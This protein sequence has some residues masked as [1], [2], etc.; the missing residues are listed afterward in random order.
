MKQ[1]LLLFLTVILLSMTSVFAQSG[2]TGPLTWEITGNTL[3]ISGIGAMPNYIPGT[4]PAP[5]AP[6]S[7]TTIIIENGVTSIGNN[8]FMSSAVVTIS[9]PESITAIGS[10]AFYGCV[11]LG[12]ATIPP[13]VTFIGDSVFMRCAALATLHFNATNCDSVGTSWLLGTNFL[14]VVGTVSIGANVERVPDNF[15]SNHT[16]ITSITIPGAVTKIGNSAFRGCTGLNSIVIPNAVESIENSAFQGCTGLTSVTIGSAVT[17]IGFSVFANCTALATVNYNA[18][19][20][21]SIFYITDTNHWLF[22]TTSLLTVIIGENVQIIPSNFIRGRT[23]ITSIIIPDAV[24]TI[25]NSAFRGCSG[26]NSIIIPNAVTSIE[27]SAFNSCTGLTSATI[28]SAVTSIGQLTFANCTALATINFNAVNCANIS[29]NSHWL[30]GTTS[31]TTIVIG[32]N[33]EGIPDN[34]IRAHTGITSIIIPDAVTT[35]GISAFQ[36]SGIASITFPDALTVIDNSAFQGCTGL[37]SIEIPNLVTSIG[38]LAFAN[39]TALET[40]TFNAVNCANFYFSEDTVTSHWLRNTTSLTTVVIGENVQRIPDNVFRNRNGITTVTIPNSVTL[41][42]NGAFQDCTGLESIVVGNSV[43]SIGGYAFYNCNALLSVTIP[44]SVANIGVYAFGECTGLT[45]IVTDAVTPPNTG[46]SAFNNVPVNIPVHIPCLTYSNYKNATGWVQFTNFITNGPVSP[47]TVEY[48]RAKCPGAPF[49]DDNF[50]TPIY[51]PGTYCAILVNV[52]NCDSVVCLILS[53]Y[54]NLPVISYTATFCS[55]SSYSDAN[56][57]NLTQP[58]T[59]EVVYPNLHGCDSIVRLQL[60]YPAPP[61]SQQLCMVSTN[62]NNHNEIVWKKQEE[63]VSYNIYRDDFLTGNYVLMANIESSSPNF[64]I[65]M[66][67]Y[68]GHSYV[69]TGVD[70]CGTQSTPG[71]AHRVMFLEVEKKTDN[72]W[73]LTWNAY[74]GTS[75]S[76]YKIYR[77][78]GATLGEMEPI[79]S[80]VAGGDIISFN[81]PAVPKDTVYYMIEIELSEPCFLGKNLSSIRSNIVMID[82]NT[83]TINEI[84]VDN[85]KLFPNPVKNELFITSD[86]KIDKVELYT[87][88]GSLVISE[89]N[90]TGKISTRSLVPG[91]YFVRVYTEKGIFEKKVVK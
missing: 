68:G 62:E 83:N 48:H 31:L 12:S 88:T 57:T 63:V 75:F 3:T 32:E 87:L 59:Y 34:F 36:G 35:I 61:P 22:G 14:G 27:N 23:G 76:T 71:T 84:A 58:G 8:A 77:S 91:L 9:I 64:W 65:D 40:V 42:G 10:A 80:I 2:T 60:T 18:T 33:V 73:T 28:G 78:V 51:D 26:L 70:S 43:I 41:I 5:W 55:G 52:D 49:T 19:N 79:H 85:I 39:C 29:E 20:C 24:T 21:I 15:I 53:E 50:T 56:F 44:N 72:S 66:T 38:R 25:G 11:G 6:Y 30:Q 67:N 37:T 46:I 90:F 4:L 7:V 47:G 54:Q 89:Q 69:I 1:K 74:K 82:N 86:S 81:D 16:G 45:F 13:A 17:S